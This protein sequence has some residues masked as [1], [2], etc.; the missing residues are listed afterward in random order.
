M[1]I[2]LILSRNMK[3]FRIQLWFIKNN[4][5]FAKFLLICIFYHQTYLPINR[6]RV[7]FYIC[8]YTGLS[9]CSQRLLIGKETVH[10]MRSPV[11]FARIKSLPTKPIII[12]Y[13]SLKSRLSLRLSLLIFLCA[14][15]CMARILFATIIIDNER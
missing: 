15:R 1:A 7:I 3:H 9:Y 4:F 2:T 12:S 5:H 6:Y 10:R 13:K 14:C 8:P 11:K